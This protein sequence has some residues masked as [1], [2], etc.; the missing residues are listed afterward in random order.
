MDTLRNSEHCSRIHPQ[1]RQK[2]C[3]RRIRFPRTQSMQRSGKNAI[4]R[5]SVGTQR[6]AQRSFN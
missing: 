4:S 2:T 3:R 6:N 1:G 5:L